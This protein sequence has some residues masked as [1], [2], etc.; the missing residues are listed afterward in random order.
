MMQI[1]KM[2]NTC[3][4]MCDTVLCYVLYI[5]FMSDWLIVLGVS[6]CGGTVFSS[7]PSNESIFD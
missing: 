1:L 5:A 6:H 4:K 3:G 7:V 2:G